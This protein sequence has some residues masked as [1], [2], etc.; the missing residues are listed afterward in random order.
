MCQRAALRKSCSTRQWGAI[1]QK[2]PAKTRIWQY[3]YFRSKYRRSN[4]LKLLNLK[5]SAQC[6]PPRC[7]SFPRIWPC[8][9]SLYGLRNRA[10]EPA[11]V[12]PALVPLSGPA[13]PA[14]ETEAS[15][16]NSLLYRLRPA[17]TC[18]EWRRSPLLEEGVHQSL[19]SQG[20]D[21]EQPDSCD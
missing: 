15:N 13:L 2:G 7:L 17:P 8:Q 19:K 3:Y 4:G 12:H 10:E 16:Q 6:Y 18:M 21:L 20:G 14:Q 1:I 9:P 5:K 11:A